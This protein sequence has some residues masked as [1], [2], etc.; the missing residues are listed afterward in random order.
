VTPPIQTRFAGAIALCLVLAGCPPRPSTG[1]EESSYDATVA[2][3]T[4][5]D[6]IYQ[7]EDMRAKF[8]ATLESE[9]FRRAR[10]RE[11]ARRLE[12]GAQ[13]VDLLSKQERAESR[14]HTVF[15]LGMYVDPPRDNSFGPKSPW[16]IT[17]MTPNEEI[18]PD[19][20]EELGSPNENMRTLY[21]Y[22]DVFWRAYKVSFPLVRSPG[23]WTL[24]VAS[25]LGAA[26]LIYLQPTGGTGQGSPHDIPTSRSATE[27]TY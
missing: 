20:I 5:Q 13:Q 21:P 26:K 9:P 3:W 23:P 19:S 24:R 17:L 7:L 2:R 10:V 14:A 18:Q 11:Q 25:D 12:L 8:A 15:F 4:A 27:G 16:R 6:D 1:G 22:L